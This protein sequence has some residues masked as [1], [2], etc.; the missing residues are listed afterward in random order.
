[1][2]MESYYKRGGWLD[3]SIVLYDYNDLGQLITKRTNDAYGFYSYHYEYDEGDNLIK[4]TYCRDENKGNSKSNFIPGKEF[5]I[6][7]ETFEHLIPGE[8]QYKKLFYNNKGKLYKENMTY[9][10]VHGN[11]TE[12]TEKYIVTNKRSSINY[13]YDENNRLLKISEIP[14]LR[15]DS[16]NLNTFTYDEIGNIVSEEINKDGKPSIFREY[17]YGPTMLLKDR[18]VKDEDTK[19]INIIRYSYEFF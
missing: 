8:N 3:T 12:E 13:E 14:D 9:Y 15:F 4:E 6:K 2:Q 5:T 18:L 16:K 1:M 19:A 17:L 11:K 7:S 10:N